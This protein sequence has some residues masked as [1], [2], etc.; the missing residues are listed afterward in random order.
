MHQTLSYPADRCINPTLV[1]SWCVMTILLSIMI[2]GEKKKGGG[3]REDEMRKMRR[4]KE[5]VRDSDIKVRDCTAPLSTG[6]SKWGIRE[7]FDVS[8]VCGYCKC[9]QTLTITPEWRKCAVHSPPSVHLPMWCICYSSQHLYIR[10]GVYPSGSS[11]SNGWEQWLKCPEVE[12]T[13]KPH[14]P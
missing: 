10:L 8:W 3:R 9:D 4:R 2:A 5:R 6:P 13:E 7:W 11:T 12:M 14:P 1:S